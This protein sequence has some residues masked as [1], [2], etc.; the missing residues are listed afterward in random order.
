MLSV[1]A[2]AMESARICL[3]MPGIYKR[4]RNKRSSTNFA[5]SLEI[6]IVSTYWI[7]K[8]LYIEDAAKPV[9]TIWIFNTKNFLYVFFNVNLYSSLMI[10]S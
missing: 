9:F 8:K 10:S 6:E 4:S 7:M 3:S 1:T 2:M 5:T